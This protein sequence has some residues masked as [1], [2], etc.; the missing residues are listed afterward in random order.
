MN[1]RNTHESREVSLTAHKNFDIS[2][3]V[4]S[5]QSF[6]VEP[7]IDTAIPHPLTNPLIGREN[8]LSV[9]K[10]QLNIGGDA[11]LTALNGLPGVGKTALSITLAND[12]EIRAH[13]RD[14]VLWAALGPD[15]D[16]TGIMSR[17]SKLLGVPDAKLAELDDVYKWADT[18]NEAIG[19]RVML[20]VIDD[21]WELEHA[22]PLRIGG[23]N[24]AHLLTTRFPDIGLE[25]INEKE[26]TTLRELDETQ[27]MEL[28][29][30]LAPIVVKGN[31]ERSLALIR[32]VG[33][34]PLALTLVG[35]YLN[36]EAK[37]LNSRRIRDAFTHLNDAAARMN[38]S[39]S[40]AYVK[41]HPSLKKGEHISLQTL[42]AVTD[43]RLTEQERAALYAL[44]I[45][46]PK[47]GDF[48][49][50]AA[51]AITHCETS[52]L[53]ALHDTG[54]L[55]SKSEDRYTLH[56][57]IADY[58]HL[59]L[60][61]RGEQQAV[62]DNLITYA[63]HTITQ[64]RKDYDLLEREQSVILHAL[65][66]AYTLKRSSELIQGATAFTPFLLLRA[67]YDHAHTHLT[68]AHELALATN[69]RRG[70]ISTHLYLGELDLR[71]NH[72][73][74]ANIQLHKGLILARELE[75]KDLICDLLI[76]LG[77]VAWKRGE[78]T[79]ARDYFQEGL[80]IARQFN[81]VERICNLLKSLDLVADSM[82]ESRLGLAYLQEGVNLAR[83]AE[84][85]E[86]LCVMLMNLGVSIG[87]QGDYALAKSHYQEGLI[88]AKQIGHKE[89][90]SAL[91]SNLGDIAII[92]KKYELAE[93]YLH[94]GLDIAHQIH[95]REW[96]SLL[97]LNLGLVMREQ[98]RYGEAE[99]EMKRGLD[100]ARQIGIPY[101]IC[102]G[103]YEYG[104]LFLQ[105]DEIYKAEDAFDRMFG[106]VPEGDKEL[107]A[108]AKYGLAQISK[109]RGNND[110]AKR[111]ADDSR[112]TLYEIGN[113]KADEVERWIK[114]TLPVAC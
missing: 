100:I 8:E 70:I 88:I 63:L 31:E 30:R 15:P 41:G 10:Q 84:N 12:T 13:F 33:G 107:V 5:S 37:G 74:A 2:N 96:L 28:L 80:I 25:F 111:L 53:D 101:I 44:S 14:G 103:L 110:K 52:D 98:K 77:G 105:Q 4:T 48:S 102:N 42:F 1:I 64:H 18:L 78:N 27:S 56:Q 93:Q 59:K 24:C 109:A 106:L 81:D 92:Q 6:Q 67:L 97:Y 20:I 54:L 73:D 90:I 9:V 49:E 114:T 91:L 113:R 83:Q 85:R 108:L 99:Q 68:R 43:S 82:G 47:P 104:I 35:N 62:Q 22:L 55:E 87:G 38:L 66:T 69:D 72:Y 61:E 57:T 7:V 71:Q 51:L 45:L 17:W 34:L 29:Q 16:L 79:Q 11:A 26:V 95:N 89:W 21:A 40:N 32:A 50:E 58:A 86:Q 112:D 19:L 76:N 3:D 46:P 39:I 60:L 94:E 36:K 75:D 23:P 65:N